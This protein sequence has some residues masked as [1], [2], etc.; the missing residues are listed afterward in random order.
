MMLRIEP[1]FPVAPAS[2]GHGA[3]GKAM[4][5]PIAALPSPKARGYT[6]AMSSALVLG[7]YG[8]LLLPVL[9]A[10]YRPKAGLPTA[11]LYALGL[12]LLIGGRW[13]SSASAVSVEG[14][15]A[16]AEAEGPGEEACAQV[17]ELT[18]Q[19]RIVRSRQPSNRVVVDR[20]VW[21]Q[22]PDQTRATLLSC[23]R[24]AAGGAEVEIVEE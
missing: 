10:Y 8:L 15:V 14:A 13:G 19:M 21:A 1:F 6:D 2:S 23:F 16:R 3:H 20:A 12:M 5:G 22:L 24:R 7:L 18:D 4:G 17:L 9:L 11:G